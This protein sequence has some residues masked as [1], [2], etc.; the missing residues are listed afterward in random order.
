MRQILATLPILCMLSGCA[1]Q[2]LAFTAKNQMRTQNDIY[3]SQVLENL[4][5]NLS[6]PTTL[7]HFTLLNSGVPSTSDRGTLT[8]GSLT[9]PARASLEALANQR[10]GSLGPLGAERAVGANWT[11]TP[12]NDPDRL[13]AMRSLYLWI[14]G[15]PL[16]D[17]EDA[18]SRLRK[19]LGEGFTLERVPRG[20][21]KCGGKHDVP[22]SACQRLA[23][24]KTH[25]WVEPGM[26]EHLTLVTLSVLGLGTAQPAKPREKPTQTVTWEIDPRTGTQMVKVTRTLENP[27]NTKPTPIPKDPIRFSKQEQAERMND[28]PSPSFRSSVDL[29]SD[30][31]PAPPAAPAAPFIEYLNNY[32]NPLI[33]PGLLSQPGVR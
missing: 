28:N 17:L 25:Y 1:T 8:I 4:A 23:R 22:E 24:H 32:S 11:I 2:Q 15:R 14:N 21:L 30:A 6:D 33:S 26:E 31:L 29:G 10:G 7:P 3:V 5:E 9:F 18:D 27:D 12:V 16:A 20:W 13:A 19:Y